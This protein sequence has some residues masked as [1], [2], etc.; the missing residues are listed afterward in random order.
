MK[1]KT[2]IFFVITW[3]SVST[4]LLSQP[5]PFSPD[6]QP[7]KT[8]LIVKTEWA[9]EGYTLFSPIAATS[10]YLID[11]DGR[12]VH[13][14][15]CDYEPGQAV[16]LLENGHLLRT[17]FTG[18]G[19]NPTFHGGGSGGQVQEFSWE[20][21]LLWDFIYN[22]KKHMLH[23]DIERLPNV[24][25]LM[26]AWEHKT[27]KQ[28]VAAG[29]DLETVG[30]LGLWPDS[31]IEVKPALKTK[32]K[33]VWE[34]HIWDHLVQDYDPSREN[35]GTISDTPQ[36]INLNPGDWT[37]GLTRRQMEKL[38]SLGYLQ[39]V[40]KKD[41]RESHPDWT[42]INSI[43]YNPELDQIVL[44]VLGFNE[45]WIID[46]STTTNEAR[47]HTGGRSG[48]GG[49]F[50]YRWGNPQVYGRGKTVDQKLFAQHDAR[51]FHQG[52][53]EQDTFWSSTTAGAVPM[54]NTAR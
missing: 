52:P 54:E 25:V 23:H 4:I 33:I 44:S 17:A 48:R 15:E 41:P 30:D 46:H 26:I 18:P 14:W 19:S 5:Q 53:R 36:L 29:R 50:I 11:L 1:S 2:A 27:D 39:E 40:S 38:A 3:L 37:K 49:D 9:F 8:G 28:A 20:G 32:G 35:Y 6:S 42:H 21:D 10:T 7:A 12:L 43:D 16:Y 22:N 34:W 31:I 24:N 47:G 51:G 13:S 45:V